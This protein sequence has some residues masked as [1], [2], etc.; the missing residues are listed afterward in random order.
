MKIE[1]Y[2]YCL[3]GCPKLNIVGDVVSKLNETENP[4]WINQAIS[5]NGTNNEE[6]RKL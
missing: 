2:I 6:K 5:Q 1:Q 4:Q 3:L